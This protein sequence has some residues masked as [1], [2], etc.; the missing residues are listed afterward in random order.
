VKLSATISRHGEE[1]VLTGAGNGPIDTFIAGLSLPVTVVDY[2]EHA[3]GAGASEQ[4]V[5]VA[6]GDQ[7]AQQK[8]IPA[9]G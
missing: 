6:Q 3:I 2:H 9:T 8:T 4:H 7:P 5:A 1:C